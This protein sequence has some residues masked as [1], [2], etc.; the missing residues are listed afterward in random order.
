LRLY[1][2]TKVGYDSL[3]DTSNDSIM[4]EDQIVVW[5]SPSPTLGQALTTYV[6]NIS[7]NTVQQQRTEQYNF[8]LIKSYFEFIL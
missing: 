3:N 8:I 6:P 1:L 4:V 7:S 5:R 2:L